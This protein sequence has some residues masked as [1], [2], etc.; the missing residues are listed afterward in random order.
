MAR[1]ARSERREHD[2][3][4]MTLMEHLGELRNRIIIC[5]V[6]VALAAVIGFIIYPQL[7]HW[8]Q[9]PLREATKGMPCSNG[10]PK[11]T[12]S[13]DKLITTDY[14]QPFIVRLKLAS[15]FGILV[16]SPIVL[17]EI[18]KFVTPGLNVRERKYALPFILTSIVLFLLGAVVAWF[19]L[20][21]ALN[22]LISIGGTSIDVRSTA[23]A[24]VT[25]VGLMFLAFGLSFEFPVLLV[26]LLL[27]G[28]LTTA[29]LRKYRRHAIVGITI[30]AAVITP[31]QD[32]YSLFL[33]AVPMWIFYEA[34]IV[35][36]RIMKR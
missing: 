20:P 5:A 26:F 6:A 7:L 13:C 15:Y 18:W 19:T 28:V 36:G 1:H 31:S 9:G 29:T 21:K 22:F 10:G 23:N 8:L 12:T 3:G 16:A 24:Y 17:W 4:R 33:M 27:V 32:P 34:S 2:E 30:F 14:L 25:L 11:A 35:I